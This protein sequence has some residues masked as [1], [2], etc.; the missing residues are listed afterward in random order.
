MITIL[1]GR[2]KPNLPAD[3]THCCC[4]MCGGSYNFGIR[5][6]III[7]SNGVPDSMQIE[8]PICSAHQAFGMFAHEQQYA[9]RYWRR[10]LKRWLPE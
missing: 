1:K 4:A 7:Y 2:Q 8:C 10:I 5:D 3:R 9:S 6:T